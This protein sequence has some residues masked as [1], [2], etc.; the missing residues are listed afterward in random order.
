MSNRDDVGA[1]VKTADADGSG[2]LLQLLILRRIILRSNSLKGN[3]TP[4]Q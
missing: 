3:A 1:D 2:L 4:N